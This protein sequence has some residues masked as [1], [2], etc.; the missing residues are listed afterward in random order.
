M[1]KNKISINSIKN[2]RGDNKVSKVYLIVRNLFLFL[3]LGGL[4]VAIFNLSSSK[5]FPVRRVVVEASFQHISQQTLRNTI[6]PYIKK[7]FF[8]VSIK[9]LRTVLL[10]LPWSFEVTV[11]R[12][13]P[14]K[15]LVKIEEQKIVARWNSNALLNSNGKIFIP[16]KMLVINNLPLLTGS[17]DQVDM[18]WR[19]YL[20][21]NKF[22]YPMEFYVV[23]MDL[24]PSKDVKILLNNGVLIIITSDNFVMNIDS[25]VKN[26]SQIIKGK[27]DQVQSI[28]FRYNNGF[29]VKWK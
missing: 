29:A 23:R 24:L 5:V 15:L 11:R 14:D 3:I 18:I 10:K 19:Y 4:I 8:L 1:D 26:Y 6:I 20:D 13:W 2:R 21:A 25:F 22:L 16:P 27:K 17:D 12:V 7:S 9:E 28:D